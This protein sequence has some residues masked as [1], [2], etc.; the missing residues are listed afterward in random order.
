MS[1]VLTNPIVLCYDGSA[2]AAQAIERAGAFLPGA[3]ALILTVWQPTAALGSFD[4]PGTTSPTVDFYEMDRAAAEEGNR[5][6]HEGERLAREAGL[7]AEPLAVEAG[8]PVWKTIVETAD[9]R[10]AA[11]IVLG[12][13]GLTGLRS[14]L[15][16]S[17]SGAVVHHAHLPT[18]V[19]P[20]HTANS[21]P[22]LSAMT[23]KDATV[24]AH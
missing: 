3:H 12:S 21:A 15:L 1:T 8:G 20:R 13:R 22:G 5:L 11:M 7:V 19:V 18:M 2:N 4:W 6:A 23:G 24:M 14:V 17:V 16:G 10:D 9:Q